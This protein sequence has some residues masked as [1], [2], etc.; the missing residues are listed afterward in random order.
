MD[1]GTLSC[2]VEDIGADLLLCAVAS[3]EEEVHIVGVPIDKGSIII[4]ENDIVEVVDIEL[5][6]GDKLL[7]EQDV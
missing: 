1:Q 3:I 5:D 2:K 4:I 7:V 6:V